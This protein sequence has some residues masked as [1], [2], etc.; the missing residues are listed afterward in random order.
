[1][2]G[3]PAGTVGAARFRVTQGDG[4]RYHACYDLAALAAFNNAPRLAVRA[5]AWIERLRQS[6]ETRGARCTTYNSAF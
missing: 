2:A 4:P 1:M 3:G 5:T 6:S